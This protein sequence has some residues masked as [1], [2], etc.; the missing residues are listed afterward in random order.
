MP[1]DSTRAILAAIGLL[2]ATASVSAACSAG[3]RDSRTA[4]TPDRAVRAGAAAAPIAGAGSAVTVCAA[5]RTAIAADM[6]PLGSA[7]GS[8][9]GD[10]VGSNSEG[11]EEAVENVNAALRK[12]G[13]DIAAA[14]AP[15]TDATLRTAVVQAVGRVNALAADPTYMA[16]VDSMDDI[17]AVT[18]KLGVATSP[19]VLAC[20]GS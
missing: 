19:I 12:I 4:S 7:L 16:G 2:V 14:S 9:I 3:T 10:A 11:R 6:T 15:A 13:T 8:V 17:P 18:A 1:R 5:L 20:Q